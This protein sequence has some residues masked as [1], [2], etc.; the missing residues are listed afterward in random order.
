MRAGTGKYQA[1]VR[2]RYSSICWDFATFHEAYE[3]LNDQHKDEIK[4]LNTDID[5]R[6][7]ITTKHGLVQDWEE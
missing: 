1:W 3:Y 4:S 5:F 2:R 6:A 7:R